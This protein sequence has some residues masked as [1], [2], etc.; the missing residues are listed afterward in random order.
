M[1][2]EETNQEQPGEHIIIA[3][4]AT[5]QLRQSR[6]ELDELLFL[7]DVIGNAIAHYE[8]ELH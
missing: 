8:R 7:Y 1:A 4:A 6:F 2:S 5:G 3:Y